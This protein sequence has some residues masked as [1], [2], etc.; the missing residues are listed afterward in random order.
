MPATPSRLILNPNAGAAADAQGYARLRDAAA[1]HRLEVCESAG[2]GDIERLAREAVRR[3]APTVVA[4]G[5]DGTVSEVINGLSEDFDR[6]RLAI[7]PLGTA[8]DF[9]RTLQLP[10]DDPIAALA[11][12]DTGIEHRIDLVDSHEVRPG[13]RQRYIINAATG[14]FSEVVH[15]YL[16]KDVKQRW[17]ALAYLRAGLDA[18]P[19]VCYHA[20]TLEID[21]TRLSERTCAVVVANGRSAGGLVLAPEASVED[22][23][24]DVLIVRTETWFDQLRLAS[25]FLFGKHLDSEGIGFHH[26]RRV[27][28]ETNPPMRFSADGE[29]VGET[30]IEFRV[31][32]SALRVLVPPA[33]PSL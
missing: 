3:G 11:L 20:A 15:D 6:C 24:L 31:V 1:A 18:M 28:I 17:G 4:A 8:N 27:R 21:G 32:P 25:R 33:P 5:G 26:A 7:V 10:A 23:R 2:V 9:A 12:L 19:E 13:G 30:P 14:G 16:D 29:L 22:E